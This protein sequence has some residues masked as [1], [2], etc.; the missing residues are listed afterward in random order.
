[1]FRK[2]LKGIRTA[3]IVLAGALFCAALVV[4]TINV[5]FRRIPQFPALDWAEEF[6]RYCSV[7]ITFVGMSLCAE[8]DLHVGVDIVYQMS[9]T[10]LKK[11]LK[12]IC[13]L[14]AC[15]FCAVF[16]YASGK[17]VMMALGFGTTSP[18]MRVPMW[19]IYMAMPV[20][21]AL[22][23]IQYFLKVV[24]YVRVKHKSLEEKP[25]EDAAE[26]D[27]LKLN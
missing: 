15:A 27:L 2:V 12:I 16:T 9:P 7:W 22:S 5:F 17:Y 25:V 26:I 18:V 4:L 8:D 1:M 20:G 23:T 6:M 3:E 10:L 19:I 24:F 14:A 21:A 13:M 11:V